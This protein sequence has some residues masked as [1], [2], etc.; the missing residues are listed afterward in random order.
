MKVICEL[1]MKTIDENPQL[2]TL[3][4]KNIGKV[5]PVPRF[6]RGI[7][8][9]MKMTRF[10]HPPKVVRRLDT[11]EIAAYGFGDASGM[12]FGHTLCIGGVIRSEF[13]K[14]NS[15]IEEKYSNYKELRYLV[16]AVKATM[17]ENVFDGIELFFSL[18]ILSLNA[19]IITGVPTLV[20][21]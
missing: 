14:W 18:I 19:P 11:V 4:R 9:L 3:N 7:C 1:H 13:G 2:N 8:A 20:K 15:T 21:S 5:K 12:G 10:L 17:E 16:N 6:K